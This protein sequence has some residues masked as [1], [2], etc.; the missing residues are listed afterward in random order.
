MT[1]TPIIGMHFAAIIKEGW[2]YRVVDGSLLL[3]HIDHPAYLIDLATIRDGDK[4]PRDTDTPVGYPP[5]IR[6]R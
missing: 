2:R 5:P 1:A 6:G 3:T 4:L